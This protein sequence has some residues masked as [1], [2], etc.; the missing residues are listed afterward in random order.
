MKTPIQNQIKLVLTAYGLIAISALS[1]AAASIK[2][3]ADPQWTDTGITLTLSDTV[4]LH[5]AIGLWDTSLGPT[6]PQGGFP[7]Y[8]YDEWITN[9]FHGQLIGF[10]GP[11]GTDPNLPSAHAQ[12]R[13][14]PQNDP[15]LFEIGINS[16]T[17]TGKEGRLWLGF[18]DSYRS[19]VFDNSGS[20][21]VQVDFPPQLKMILSEANVVLTWPTNVVGFDYSGFTLQSTTN[22]GSSA[23]WSSVS[24]VPI[25]V[26]GQS[27]VTNP[28]SGTQKFFRLSQ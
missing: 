10:I 19:E 17:I 23:V 3:T 5:D 2:V 8:E 4:M 15:S 28:I 14:V 26:N 11:V 25:V 6:G 24:P 13:A 12:P 20:V 1:I 18:N 16:I 21:F 7:G 22:F 9:G 27:T